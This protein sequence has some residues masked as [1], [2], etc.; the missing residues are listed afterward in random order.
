LGFK[1]QT[2]RGM[3][4]HIW[5]IIVKVLIKIPIIFFTKNERNDFYQKMKISKNARVAKSKVFNP[6][7]QLPCQFLTDFVKLIIGQILAVF[8]KNVN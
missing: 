6:Y 3:I 4:F 1:K 5:I 7:Y 8:A 2:Q